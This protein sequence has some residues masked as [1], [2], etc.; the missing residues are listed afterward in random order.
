MATAR[1]GQDVAARALQ[2][3]CAWRATAISS[4]GGADSLGGGGSGI[5][6]RHLNCNWEALKGVR[7][8]S[9]IPTGEGGLW[10]GTRRPRLQIVR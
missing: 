2:P 8:R 4:S 9:A 5:D 10:I 1:A 6:D 3:V 7:A